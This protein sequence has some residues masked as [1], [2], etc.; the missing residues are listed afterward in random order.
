[1]SSS[2]HHDVSRDK[3]PAFVGLFAG[4]IVLGALTY[5]MVLWTNAQF[6]GHGAA[7]KGAAAQTSTH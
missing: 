3:G 5:G 2:H 7:E 6:A 4:L 1:M